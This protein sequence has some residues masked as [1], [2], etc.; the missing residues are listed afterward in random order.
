MNNTSEVAEA[1]N[2]YFWV[3]SHSLSKD[4]RD[5]V[6]TNWSVFLK[7]CKLIRIL[8]RICIQS[9]VT[10][11]PHS[12]KCYGRISI[13]PRLTGKSRL[14]NNFQRRIWNVLWLL[15]GSAVR[16]FLRKRRL[17]SPCQ[18]TSAKWISNHIHSVPTRKKGRKTC[19]KPVK[20]VSFFKIIY[21]TTRSYTWTIM[22][23]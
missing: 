19:Q 16:G 20:S 8:P 17:S 9:E 1:F 13:K 12:C 5:I 11:P 15:L 18:I 22:S 21:K 4:V 23:A 2:K 3:S 6:E 14:I 7:E 10:W